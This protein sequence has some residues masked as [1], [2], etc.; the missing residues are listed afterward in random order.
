MAGQDFDALKK[1]ALTREFKPVPLGLK[2]SLAIKNTLR[3]IDSRN[4]VAQARRQ[5]SRSCK[6]EYVVYT[7]HWDHFGVGAPVKGDKIY[8]GALDNASG[9]AP[10]LEIARAFTQVEA[11]AEALDP[12]PDGH[13][14]R[15]GAARL[16]VLRGHAALSAREDRS[17]TSTSTASTS[18]AGPRTSPSSAWAR[19]ISTTTSATPPP[20]RAARC[21]P[22]PS[23]RRASTTG[24][25]TST[26]PSRACRRSTPTP[27]SSTSASRRSYSKQKRDEYTNNDYHAPSDQVKPDWDLAAP[28]RTP[29]LL[30]AVGYR[31]ANADKFPEW[32]PATSSGRS[33]RDAEEVAVSQLRLSRLSEAADLNGYWQLSSATVLS[34]LRGRCS[35]A[36][37]LRRT[38]GAGLI[39]RS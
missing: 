9:V 26:S 15:A 3:T 30:F 36:G 1:Q 2:A 7:A 12:V 5:R 24:R 13:R 31:V 27:A 6:D 34:G 28:S 11:G 39:P 20:S 35:R 17:P 22:I 33:A 8:N 4:V 10:V 29:Q 14:R 32:K 16:A 23:R 19:R 18:G 38:R 25:I 37:L 21:G